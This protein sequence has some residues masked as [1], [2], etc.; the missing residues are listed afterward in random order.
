M[1][2][3]PELD[4]RTG[5]EK[6]ATY[7]YQI[8]TWVDDAGYPVSVAV[9]AR[10]NPGDLSAR[11]AAPAGLVVPTDREVSLTGSHIRPQPGYGYDERRHVTVWGPATI[12][13]RDRRRRRPHRLGLG[14]GRGPVLRVLGAL[15][16][17]VARATSMRCRPSAGRRSS[18]KLSFG[19]LTLRTT[20]LPFLTATIVPV[21]L[22]ILIAASHGSFDARRGAADDHRRVLRPARAQRR[23]RRVRHDVQGADDANVTPT[24]FSGG[25]RVIQ[26]GLVTLR[27]MA[28]LSTVF[29]VARRR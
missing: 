27:Q 4:A 24:Q 16:R 15:R 1:R 26:Y 28:T 22:G 21:T 11:F 5:L 3:T 9:D 23:Q 25:S 2:S 18:R 7:P 13:R 20:R 14:R 6:L 12:T 8:L 17:Q 29:Y 19:F 10:I